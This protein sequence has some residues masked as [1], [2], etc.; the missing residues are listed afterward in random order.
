[1]VVE[2]PQ[3]RFTRGHVVQRRQLARHVGPASV[4][5]AD[6]REQRGQVAARRDG[7]GL[8]AEL[9]ALGFQGRAALGVRLGGGPQDV[10]SGS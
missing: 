2:L 5:R 3:L 7:L 10:E 9:Q 1:M 6:P 8:L 4:A